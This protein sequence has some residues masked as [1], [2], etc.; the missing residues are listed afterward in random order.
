[1]S[2]SNDLDRERLQFEREKFQKEYELRERELT[3]KEKEVDN[4]KVKIT[5]THITIWVAV[6]GLLGASI[7]SWL[8]GYNN[9][10]LERDKFEFQVILKA[11][12][13]DSLDRNKKNLQF[14][15]DAGI[16]SDEKHKIRQLLASDSF[17]LKIGLLEDRMNQLRPYYSIFDSTI[18]VT[19]EEIRQY[20]EGHKKGS[21]K[22][23]TK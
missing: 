16:I 7:S 12:T 5:P 6:I 11:A 14:L 8:Q 10:K 13:S 20:I 3:L 17:D 9:T 19:D 4:N 15:L 21:K 2:N 18:K 23:I 22:Y 1:M